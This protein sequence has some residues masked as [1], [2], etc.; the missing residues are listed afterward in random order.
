MAATAPHRQG[1]FLACG[2]E[3][4]RHARLSST[5]SRAV[6]F[7]PSGGKRLGHSGHWSGMTD[8]HEN[9]QRNLADDTRF[10]PLNELNERY[11][12]YYY[13]YY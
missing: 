9:A 1:S 7:S 13:Y 12:Y 4:L 11:Y 3:Q 5:E 2:D 10:R 6:W 8:T